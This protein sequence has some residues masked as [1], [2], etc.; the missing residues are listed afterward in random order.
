MTYHELEPA[1]LDATSGALPARPTRPLGDAI[2]EE[3]IAV[4]PFA[5]V[6]RG[7]C[8]RRAWRLAVKVIE[9]PSYLAYLRRELP[10]RRALRHPAVVPILGADLDGP[11]P[12]VVFPLLA[13]G[14]LGD[15]LAALRDAERPLAPVAAARIAARVLAILDDLHDRGVRHRCIRPGNVLLSWRTRAMLLGGA[16][17]STEDLGVYL[18]EV[19][20]G[21]HVPELSRA[22]ELASPP[23]LPT[24]GR[25]PRPLLPPPDSYLAPEARAGVASSP[26]GPGEDVWATGVLLHALLAGV[27]EPRRFP[28]PV[29]DVSGELSELLERATKPHPR[30][31]FDGVLSMARA[32]RET[33]ELRR[34]AEPIGGDDADATDSRGAPR[35]ARTPSSERILAVRPALP[36]GDSWSE[37]R[38]A[39]GFGPWEV[40]QRPRIVPHE[41]GKS[42]GL[43]LRI[44]NVTSG[45]RRVVV[46]H[47]PSWLVVAGSG[48]RVVGAGDV[49][50]IDLFTRTTLPLPV[51]SPLVPIEER[52]R[53]DGRVVLELVAADGG[54]GPRL[55]LPVEVMRTIGG[56]AIVVGVLVGLLPILNLIALAITLAR[57]RRTPA[58]DPEARP[59]TEL[60]I[61]PPLVIAL[62]ATTAA[63][64]VLEAL[65]LLLAG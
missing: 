38:I 43:A 11:V 62:G 22:R 49:A 19:G 28:L 50:T 65:T 34:R 1:F 3:P 39:G 57:V 45:A 35:S 20:L 26:G 44:S 61:E 42:A 59:S 23:P 25:W 2:L 32:L 53:L 17:P 46:R 56:D 47:H 37:V 41:T 13:G 12:Y 54:P 14:S 4:G 55:T 33:P 15:L 40:V 29:A 10:T 8:A 7:R 5:T 63:V 58:L 9:D 16:V 64:T 48:D 30:Y 31:R 60:P 27:P 21:A 18:A 6:W 51:G 24:P 36:S 52:A